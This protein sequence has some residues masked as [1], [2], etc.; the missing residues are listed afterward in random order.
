MATKKAMVKPVPKKPQGQAATKKP[1][2]LPPP[3]PLSPT[4]EQPMFGGTDERLAAA[5][6]ELGINRA[7]TILG[8]DAKQFRVH[9][10]GNYKPS[11]II[12]KDGKWKVSQE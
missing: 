2:I 12:F 10:E 1:K 3:P 9:F 5:I 11:L 8:T 4:P 6:K 7:Y